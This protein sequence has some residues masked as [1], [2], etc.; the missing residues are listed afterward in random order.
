ME[1]AINIVF[2]LSDGSRGVSRAERVRFEPV[3]D[4]KVVNDR[5]IFFC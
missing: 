5:D 1:C 2:F 4:G 3:V